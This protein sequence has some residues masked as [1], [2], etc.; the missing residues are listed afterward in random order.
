MGYDTKRLNATYKYIRSRDPWHLT[1]TA[2][3]SAARAWSYKYWYLLR[4]TYRHDHLRIA[5]QCSHVP[6]LLVWE[7]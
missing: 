2:I 5:S 6:L 4:P 3:T 1:F 7:I